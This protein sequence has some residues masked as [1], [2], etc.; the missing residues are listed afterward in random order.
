MLSRSL[1]WLGETLLRPAGIWM[2]RGRGHF[3]YSRYDFVMELEAWRHFLRH[4]DSVYHFIYAEKSFHLMA[5]C[6]GRNGNRL[7]GTV[8]HPPEHVDWLFRSVDHFRHLDLL[9][10]VSRA[11]IPFWSGVMGAKRVKYVPYAVDT[12]YFIPQEQ[13]RGGGRF[14]CLF[15]GHHERDL[16]VLE[17][18]VRGLVVKHAQIEFVIISRDEKCRQISLISPQVHWYRSV[19]DAEY[20]SLLQSASLLVLPLRRSTTCTA[21]LEALAC[22]VPVVTSEGGIEDYLTPECSCVT[23]PGDADAVIDCVSGLLQDPDRL[24]R[25]RQAAR[26]QAERFSWPRIAEQVVNLYISLFSS[27]GRA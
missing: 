20:L 23:P 13:A 11:Q 14:R 22:G 25:M 15:V 4:R 5:H 12:R 26:L 27:S 16:A 18:V 2:A 24:A 10:V 21:V 7:I 19:D 17:Q 3:E 6:S 9:I 1:Y 8:H